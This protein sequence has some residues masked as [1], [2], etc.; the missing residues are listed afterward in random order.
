MVFWSKEFTVD[1]PGNQ[2]EKATQLV[3]QC[4]N[5]SLGKILLVFFSG[6]YASFF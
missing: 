3:P 4:A 6:L 2:K 5:I 1:I